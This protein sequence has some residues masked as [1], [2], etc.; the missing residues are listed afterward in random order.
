VPGLAADAP[1]LV[2]DLVMLDDKPLPT[3][4]PELPAEITDV[5]AATPGAT[6]TVYRWSATTGWLRF[7]KHALAEA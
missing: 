7:G 4:A 3:I 5:W 1:F 6:G 2:L